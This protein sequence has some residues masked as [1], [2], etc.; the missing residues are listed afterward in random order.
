MQ[1]EEF[2][3]IWTLYRT[4]FPAA[5]ARISSPNVKMT[6]QVAL[7]PYAMD[8]VVDASM[9]WAR[10]S[11]FFPDIADITSAL[12]PLGEHDRGNPSDRSGQ[13]E[14]EV[15]HYVRELFS[16]TAE[17][18]KDQMHAAGLET[19]QEA[20]SHGVPYRE[21]IDQCRLVFGGRLFPP[22]SDPEE[23]PDA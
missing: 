13:W 4:L 22:E 19:L 21:W 2:E 20:E 10:R 16:H 12:T 23:R 8:D 11:K 1:A 17:R 14:H 3:K 7:A 18:R 6:W 9:E 5:S 15:T